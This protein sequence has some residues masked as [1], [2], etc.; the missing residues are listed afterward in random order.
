MKYRKRPIVVE[1]F[2][3]MPNRKEKE[4]PPWINEAIKKGIA[5]FV[6]NKDT[7]HIQMAIKTIEGVMVASRGDYIIQGTDGELYPCKP[8]I[9]ERIYEKIEED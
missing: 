7:K 8:D 9:F 5:F 3:W 2:Q 4:N 1:A 6:K